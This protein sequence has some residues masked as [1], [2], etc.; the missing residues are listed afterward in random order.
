MKW[1]DFDHYLKAEHLGGR[2]TIVTIDHVV[3]EET[4]GASG[5][6]EEKPVM[7]FRGARKGLILSPT[8]Q[9]ALRDLFGD[10]V[11]ACFDQRIQLEAITLRVAG[12]D[13]Q[14]IRISAAPTTT[15]S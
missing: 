13:T 3:V 1:S 8:N 5:K 9:R 11:Q 6:A 2:K 14:P 7:Y 10:D 12:R 15:T 4:H